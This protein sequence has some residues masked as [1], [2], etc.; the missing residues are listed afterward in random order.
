MTCPTEHSWWAVHG[1]GNVA[2]QAAFE[3]TRAGL[4]DRPWAVDDLDQVLQCLQ[5]KHYSKALL[6]VDNAG[7]DVIL[8]ECAGVHSHNSTG[9][10]SAAVSSGLTWH[11]TLERPCLPLCTVAP[12]RVGGCHA[13]Q[14]C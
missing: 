12:A 8:G 7:S 5:R 6:F 4:V 3:A 11:R 13:S 1:H 10:G 9:F 14:Q 2:L